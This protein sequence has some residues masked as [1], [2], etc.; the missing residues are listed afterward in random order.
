[1]V[2]KKSI[3]LCVVLTIITC[4]LYGLY[5]FYSLSEDA[6]LLGND[7][8]FSGG[9]SI[10]LCIV[11]CGIYGI[12]WCY[13]VGKLL[14]NAFDSRGM[15]ASDNSVLYLVLGLFGLGIVNFCIMQNDINQLALA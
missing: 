3:P 2:S 10:L 12:Y 14:F 9:M 1:M 6:A 4:G 7:N 8:S 5:W 11:T 15:R 13:K